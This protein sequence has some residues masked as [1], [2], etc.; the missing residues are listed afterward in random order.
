MK[1]GTVH[2]P[3]NLPCAERDDDVVPFLELQYLFRNYMTGSMVQVPF[4]MV[5][6]GM[7]EVPQREQ[8][9]Y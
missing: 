1:E 9:G 3:P 8:P 5:S 2:V 4:L 7:V 6:R